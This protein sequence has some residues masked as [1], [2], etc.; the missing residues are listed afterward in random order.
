MVTRYK[1]NDV[2]TPG[3][4]PEQDGNYVK[5]EDYAALE[6]TI[7]ARKMTD[8]IMPPRIEDIH[9]R[10]PREVEDMWM[11]RVRWLCAQLGVNMTAEGRA[12]DRKEQDELL[13]EWYRTEE[14]PYDKR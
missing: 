7:D 9:F 10:S 13:D 11:H 8:C 14:C 5:Y 1:F 2:V 12:A 3:M 4:Y 6:R